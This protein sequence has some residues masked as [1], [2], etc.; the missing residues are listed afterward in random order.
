[1]KLATA[2][3]HTAIQIPNRFRRRFFQPQVSPLFQPLD[4]LI[5]RFLEVRRCETSQDERVIKHS[6]LNTLSVD[7]GTV[8]DVQDG[9]RPVPKFA[10]I[11]R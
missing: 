11:R 6:Y 7:M 5:G 1:M 8:I 10:K 2:L 3:A 4:T 9:A